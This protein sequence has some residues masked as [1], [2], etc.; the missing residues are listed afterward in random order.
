M[1]LPGRSTR[2]AP[3]MAAAM[4]WP[5]AA[6]MF[7]L[8]SRWMTSVGT[9]IVGRTERM[10]YRRLMSEERGRAGSDWSTPARS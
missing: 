4:Y 7:L 9:E 6:G 3:G 10:S 8:S 5:C 1:V 2:R